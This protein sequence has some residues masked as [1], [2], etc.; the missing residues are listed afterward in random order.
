MCLW[1]QD[2][3]LDAKL[4]AVQ[5]PHEGRKIRRVAEP[6][7]IL[8]TVVPPEDYIAGVFIPLDV[9]PLT[10]ILLPPELRSGG[11]S[12]RPCCLLTEGVDGAFSYIGKDVF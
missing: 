1:F 12:R 9:S 2:E 11:S 3:P 7:A 5:N 6:E 4:T 10:E 8:N